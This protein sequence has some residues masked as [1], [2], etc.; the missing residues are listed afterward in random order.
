MNNKQKN[1]IAE[2]VG[3]AILT[4]ASLI[5]AFCAIWIFH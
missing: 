5:M 4:T 2:V 1:G 3:T